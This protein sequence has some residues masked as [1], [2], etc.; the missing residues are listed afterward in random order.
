MTITIEHINEEAMNKI[1]EECGI[2]AIDKF[3]QLEE[4]LFSINMN[5]NVI[6]K[7]YPEEIMFD[8]KGNKSFISRDDF[9]TITIE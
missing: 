9:F 8:F 1:I 6:M 2:K 3:V 4:G 5:E 7:T